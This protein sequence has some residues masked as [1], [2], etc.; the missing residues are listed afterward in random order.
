MND[1]TLLSHL[2]AQLGDHPACCV[3]FSGGLDSTV[4]LH[5]LVSLR[6]AGRDLPLRAV[7]IHHG[8]SR[9][10]DEWVAHCE[11]LCAAWQVPLTVLRV[12]V[13]GRGG[14]EAAAREARYQA[15]AAALQTGET[16]LTAQHL[17]DQCETLLLALKR[18]SGP[19]GLSAMKSAT[20]FHGQVLLRPLL[21]V[22]RQ[23][24]EGYAAAQGLAWIDDDSNQDNRFDRNFLR[25]QVL[26]VLHQRWPHFAAAASRSAALCAEQESLLDEL[27]EETLASL[28][29]AEGSLAIEALRPMSEAKRAALLRRWMARHG[30]PMPAREQI[31]RLWREVAESRADAEPQLQLGAGSVR[32]F[33]QR[34][35]LLPPLQPVEDHVLA[36]QPP[37]PLALPDGLGQLVVGEDFSAAKA[38]WVRRARPDEPVTVRFRAEGTFH[39][40]GRPHSRQIKKL[41]QELAIPPWARTRTPLIFYGEQ[42]IAAP[43]I[44]I[45][46]EGAASAGQTGWGIE[47]QKEA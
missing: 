42:L 47:W 39:I 16:L 15:L 38:R 24:L 37:E 35:Y 13:D 9:H 34:L 25:R 23:E 41:W 33:R 30:L 19:A 32:R 8:L 31:G 3:A 17:D 18:G 27:L 44:F 21:D 46:R 14:I 40:V 45:T 12:Q 5:L 36:W 26:P 2:D 22:Y 4:L 6:D 10:A 20:A 11:S 1:V 29:D 28:L 7:H 43:G